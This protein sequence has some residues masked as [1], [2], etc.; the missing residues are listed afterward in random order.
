MF[1]VGVEPRVGRHFTFPTPDRS[2]VPAPSLRRLHLALEHP[3]AETTHVV[4]D[5]LNIGNP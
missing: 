3:D 4:M 2:I 5:N 1:S